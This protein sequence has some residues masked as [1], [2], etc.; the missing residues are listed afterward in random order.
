MK[1]VQSFWFNSMGLIGCVGIVLGEDEVTGQRKAYIG[2]G[3]G[4]NELFDERIVAESGA[5]F[6]AE[7][8][9]RIAIWLNEEPVK[10]ESDSE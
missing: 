2:V 4:I 9:E 7:M 1:N 10:K 5:K 6:P 3:L 8:A